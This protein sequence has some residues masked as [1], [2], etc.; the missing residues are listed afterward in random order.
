MG[1][2]DMLILR[3]IRYDSP[4]AETLARMIAG[5]LT[6]TAP[7]VNSRTDFN[8]HGS[9]SDFQTGHSRVL[10]SDGKLFINDDWSVNYLVAGADDRLEEG[11][12]CS[13]KDRS[14]Y[15]GIE[16]FEDGDGQTSPRDYSADTSV[17]LKNDV[18]LGIE[19]NDPQ[20]L[21]SLFAKLAYTFR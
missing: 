13:A 8:G 1:F 18:R 12:E 15:F 16:Y 4:K 5:F 17:T 21:H 10:G 19:Y 20:T 14:D 11:V 3:G 6:E 7:Y 9:S 2:A